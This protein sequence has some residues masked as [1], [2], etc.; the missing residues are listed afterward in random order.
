MQAKVAVRLLSPGRHPWK[1]LAAAR[2]LRAVPALGAAAPLSGLQVGR[3][4]LDERRAAYLRGLQRLRPHRLVPPEDL[5]TNQVLAERLF[6]NRQSMGALQVSGARG[7][8]AAG[9]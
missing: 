3:S 1:G 6:F 5:S 4:G 8:A 2:L 9:P 7:G